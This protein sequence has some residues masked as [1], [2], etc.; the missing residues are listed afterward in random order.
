LLAGL[1]NGLPS[2]SKEVT[3]THTHTYTH[4]HTHAHT[5]KYIHTHTQVRIFSDRKVISAVVKNYISN[6][7][8]FCRD[9]MHTHVHKHTHSHTHTHTLSQTDT[10]M[11]IVIHTC[12]HIHARTRT[13]THMYA[14]AAPSWSAWNP[15]ASTGKFFILSVQIST[16]LADTQNFVKP[17][18]PT[19][20][21]QA[22]SECLSY[23]RAH[24]H[25]H[26]QTHIQAYNTLTHEDTHTHRHTHRTV[27]SLLLT[28]SN[29]GLPLTPE[30]QQRL[31]QPFSQITHTERKEHTGSDTNLKLF[32]HYSDT[33]QT[34]F[35]LDSNTILTLFCHRDRA[36]A[37]DLQAP[38]GATRRGGGRDLQGHSVVL[39]LPKIDSTIRKVTNTTINN[40]TNE[41]IISQMILC[42][43]N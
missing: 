39:K 1:K 4:I 40:L 9:G 6:A 36:G 24:T 27:P 20:I 8:K 29:I 17:G 7:T 5:Y 37:G 25:T 11:N 2:P 33:C 16:A 41:Q 15:T 34:L 42:E 18:A 30:E 32:C 13:H 3:Y 22:I 21:R 23:T 10:F 38:G 35:T 12:T 14:Q 26:T 19:S 28:V 43:S 31:F